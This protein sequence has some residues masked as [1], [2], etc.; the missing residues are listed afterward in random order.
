M[1]RDVGV[2]RDDVELRRGAAGGTEAGADMES[3]PITIEPRSA[4]HDN[5]TRMHQLQQ[6]AGREIQR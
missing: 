2:T 1:R 6:L 4:A 5:A 3:V